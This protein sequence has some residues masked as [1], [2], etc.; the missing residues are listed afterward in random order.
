VRSNLLKNSKRV[1][2]V[3]DYALKIEIALRLHFGY[4]ILIN[5]NKEG[6]D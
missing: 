6:K 4:W 2:S 5:Q 1:K 3:S